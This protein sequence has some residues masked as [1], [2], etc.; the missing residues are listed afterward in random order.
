M[1]VNNDGNLNIGI[2]PHSLRAIDTSL[3]GQ[4]LEDINIQNL[5]IHIHI[6][7]QEQEVYDC[8]EWCGQR[9]GERLFENFDVNK[10][11]CL[12]HATHM[13]DNE[14]KLLAKSNAVAGLCPTTEA[15]LGDGLFNA[16]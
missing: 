9:P 11:W 16:K 2:A 7:E 6:A 14:T 4:V 5:P 13:N 12:V 1:A 8:L 15:N 3:L 10:N